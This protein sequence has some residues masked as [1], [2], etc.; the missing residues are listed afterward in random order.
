MGTIPMSEDRLIQMTKDRL[1]EAGAEAVETCVKHNS[2]DDSTHLEV[3]FNTPSEGEFSWE[4]LHRIWD[5][6]R[7]D[8]ML[9][10]GGGSKVVLRLS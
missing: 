1:E 8:Y 9:A 5:D 10:R 2:I 3:Q 7:L 6:V 4:G